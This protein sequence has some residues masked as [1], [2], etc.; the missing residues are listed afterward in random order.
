MRKSIWISKEFQD[1]WSQLESDGYN[2]S[3]II[4]L[5]LAALRIFK[6]KY[7]RFPSRLEGDAWIEETTF[8]GTVLS[9]LEK[10]LDKVKSLLKKE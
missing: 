1:I 9:A 7:G 3:E 8:D 4:H 5:G 2:P 6:T 10:N